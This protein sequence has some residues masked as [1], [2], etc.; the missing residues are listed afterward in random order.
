MLR[1]YLLVGLTMFISGCVTPNLPSHVTGNFPQ[2]KPP[3]EQFYE[4]NGLSEK[5][6]SLLVAAHFDDQTYLYITAID[7][8]TS[9]QKRLIGGAKAANILPGTHTVELQFHDKNR[10][11]MPLI[12]S[13]VSVEANTG[14]LINFDA[15]FPPGYIDNP[16]QTNDDLAIRV[17]VTNLDNNAV[18]RDAT[19][20]GWG[21][22]V[23]AK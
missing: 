12:L 5:D 2:Q 13:D 8:F 9:K 3:I 18:V 7:K 14:Y 4:G 16:I 1:V 19:F 11:I 21:K 23:S 15:N 10:L 22:E 17:T 20:N 6:S